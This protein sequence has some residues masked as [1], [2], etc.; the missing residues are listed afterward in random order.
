MDENKIKQEFTLEEVILLIWKYK[1]MIILINLAF[2]VGS[3]SYS[4]VTDEIYEINCV[5]RPAQ[6]SNEVTLLESSFFTQFSFVSGKMELPVSKEIVSYLYSNDFLERYYDK[7][8]NEK[9]LFE[10]RLESIQ[11][12]ERDEKSK[13]EL[14]YETAIRILKEDVIKLSDSGFLMTIAVRGKDKYFARHFLEE[15]INDLKNYIQKKNQSILENQIIYY[16]N[17]I[18]SVDDPN[19]INTLQNTINKKIEKS[20]IISSNI[21]EIIEHPYTP[22]K[23]YWPKRTAVVII[24]SIFGF[25]FSIFF[26]FLYAYIKKLIKKILSIK[27]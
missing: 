19:I 11:V 12:S 24:V 25:V 7:Y 8:K 23:R 15:L 16:K 14:L 26:V 10:D 20:F 6:P 2:F 5:I 18:K 22:Y 1:Y 13:S 9:K 17:V 4:L 3:V 21:F 27:K